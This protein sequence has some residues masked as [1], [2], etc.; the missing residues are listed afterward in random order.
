MIFL[1][2]NCSDNNKMIYENIDQL[3]RSIKL[4]EFLN[5]PNDDVFFIK[6]QKMDQHNYLKLL[7]YKYVDKRIYF[8]STRDSLI[9]AHIHCLA[10]ITINRLDMNILKTRYDKKE[11][12][13]FKELIL[14]DLEKYEKQY[15]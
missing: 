4:K 2:N 13:T 14:K 15:N 6:F 8:I 7:D 1:I 9:N 12:E 11:T 10:N 3:L 5:K